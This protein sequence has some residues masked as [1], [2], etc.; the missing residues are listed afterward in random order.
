MNQNILPFV[1]KERFLQRF[2]KEAKKADKVY[3]ATDPD[4][5]GE[6]ISW[7]LACCLEAGREENAPYYI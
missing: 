3:L 4:R 1:E 5:E 6:A 2:R 7:H